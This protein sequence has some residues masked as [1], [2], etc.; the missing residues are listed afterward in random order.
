MLPSDVADQLAHALRDLR[1]G[2]LHLVVHDGRIV[3]IERIERIRLTE[4]SEAQTPTLGRPTPSR[5]V[6]SRMNQEAGCG[7]ECSERA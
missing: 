3:R 6:R 7:G 4:P 2:S 5:E 1:Y